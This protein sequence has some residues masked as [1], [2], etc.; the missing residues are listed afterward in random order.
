M[1][2]LATVALGLVGACSAA[3]YP[4][5]FTVL[6]PGRMPDAR[7]R[8]AAHEQR[9]D[10]SSG[11]RASAQA[12]APLG[13]PDDAAEIGASTFEMGCLEG[14]PACEADETP[15][16]RVRLSAFAIDRH[17]V[18]WAQFA[19]C[20]DA[21]ICEKVYVDRCYVWTPARRFEIGADLDAS[22][23]SA[24][25][26]VVCVTWAQAE[27]YCEA[28][29]GTLPTEAQWERTARGSRRS[30]YAWGNTPPSCE[31]AHF[32]GCG[33]TTRPVGTLAA[34]DS[35]EGV[36]DLAGNAWEWV[37]DWYHAK[38]YARLRHRLSPQGPWEGDVRVVRGG[39]FYDA[40]PDLRA[41]YRYGLTPEFGY[42]T[43]GFRCAYPRG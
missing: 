28:H 21:G 30:L 34:G 33:K 18:T 22:M 38:E 41:S 9:T 11:R 26:P 8:R 12:V 32:D 31:H 13:G 4:V 16:H 27:T 17:E 42:S 23:I 39:S 20:V 1:R 19:A 40:E 15:V 6:P 25:R 2:W 29:G 43:V 36:A 7:V 10:G 35:P 14:D 3:A 5:D 37:G 24:E